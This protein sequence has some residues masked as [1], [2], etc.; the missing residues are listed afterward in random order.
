MKVF[1]KIIA[2]LFHPIFIP[3]GGSLFYFLVT[4]KYTSLGMKMGNLIPIFIITVVIPIICF[5][6]L[7]NMGFVNSILM[8]TIK[9]RKYPTYVSLA[10]LFMVVYKVIP[11]NYTPELY[12]YFISFIIGLL[13][14]L[15]LLVL[16]FK[17]S[18]HMIGIGC[19]LTYVTNLSIHFEINLTLSISLFILATGLIASSRLYFR[20]HTKLEVLSGF[21]I[22]IISQLLT[23]SYW[24]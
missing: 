12:Y 11:Y 19:L 2:Y 20:A 15:L 21:I 13:T 14:S 17:T 23:V 8:P 7:R 3:I 16:N 18:L 4:K 9:E 10:L 24:L 22:G 6:I 5:L 1:L